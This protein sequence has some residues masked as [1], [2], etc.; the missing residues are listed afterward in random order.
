MP[1]WDTAWWREDECGDV[2]SN[3]VTRQR[4]WWP[5]NECDDA[6]TNVMICRPMMSGSSVLRCRNQMSASRGHWVLRCVAMQWRKC[7]VCHLLWW[8]FCF[9][10]EA[11]PW[12]QLRCM[13]SQ[14]VVC[15]FWFCLFLYLFL[16][17][18]HCCKWMVVVLFNILMVPHLKKSNG[19]FNASWQSLLS[20][21]AFSFFVICFN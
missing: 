3:V 12:Q 6:E 20:C 15:C 5:V 21:I 17:L 18:Q 16:S 1:K 7:F 8:S 13:K 11:I 14:F 4:M 2:G 9:A 10:A 19:Y